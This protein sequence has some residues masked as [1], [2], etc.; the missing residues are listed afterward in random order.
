MT[1]LE[2]LTELRDSMKNLFQVIAEELGIV[3]LVGWI[4]KKLK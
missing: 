2:A 3:K 1:Y 4:S